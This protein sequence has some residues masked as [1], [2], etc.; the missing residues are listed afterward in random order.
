MFFLGHG[1]ER[2]PAIHITQG[3]RGTLTEAWA[4]MG[5]SGCFHK[6]FISKVWATAAEVQMWYLASQL[7]LVPK[8]CR[9]KA[10]SPILHFSL[11]S[12][13]ITALGCHRCTACCPTVGTS[14][15]PIL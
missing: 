5:I 7:Q 4:V 3:F 15:A 11:G 6:G 8:S 1:R 13:H 9:I 10:Q 2:L 14:G 12:A